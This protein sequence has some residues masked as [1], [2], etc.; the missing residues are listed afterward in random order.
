MSSPFCEEPGNGP[1]ERPLYRPE[2]LP[3]AV[4]AIRYYLPLE[5]WSEIKGISLYHYCCYIYPGNKAWPVG[6]CSKDCSGHPSK[7][8]AR[9]HYRQFLIDRF[10]QYSGRLNSPAACAVCGR[11]TTSY[12]WIDFHFEWEAVALCPP[13]LTQEGLLAAFVLKDY[14]LLQISDTRFSAVAT[15]TGSDGLI[16][17]VMPTRPDC[18]F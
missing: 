1:S 10:G 6:Y 15:I 13:H 7:L 2:K 14:H 16:S 17:V 3:L 8:E 4:T 12:A 11:T 9:E 18:R 5:I